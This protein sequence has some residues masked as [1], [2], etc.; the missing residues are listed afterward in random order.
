[1]VQTSIKPSLNIVTVL[2]LTFD[3]NEWIAKR[4]VASKD[5]THRPYNRTHPSTSAETKKDLSA[6]KSR[7]FIIVSDFKCQ[8]QV[9]V[10]APERSSRWRAEQFCREFAKRLM[11]GLNKSLI[12]PDLILSSW[13]RR[14]VATVH[15][16]R[17]LDSTRNKKWEWV[18]SVRSEARYLKL[19]WQDFLLHFPTRLANEL[20]G[21]KLLDYWRI[22]YP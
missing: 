6:E 15:C 9:E 14:R 17:A 20:F 21:W 10:D 19:N 13:W 16:S 22:N 7:E 3:W 5:I 18:I 8:N 2:G 4:I 11:N 12:L 1:M